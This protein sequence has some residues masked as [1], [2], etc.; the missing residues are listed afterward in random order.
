MKKIYFILIAIFITATIFAQAPEKMSYQAVIRDGGGNL[1]ANQG[2]GMQISILKSTASGTAVYVETHTPT[3]NINGLVTL[4]IGAGSNP[5]G[6]FADIDWS[7]D[8]YFIKTETDLTG[9]SGYTISGTSQLLSVPFALHAK[10]VAQPVYTVNT[11]YAELGG[12][13]IE[14]SDG[15]KHGIVVAMQNQGVSSWYASNDI[16]NNAANH[17][18]DGAKFKDWRLPTKRELSLIYTV[19][20]AITAPNGRYWSS[21]EGFYDSAWFHSFSN[22]TTSN[23][24]KNIPSNVRVVRVF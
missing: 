2:I 9:G 8:T 17:D 3:S 13:V 4:E 10:T 23:L 6:V 24:A 12:Y 20:A 18:V 21:T 16:C 11:F 1:V 5:S 14:V 15:G 7:N 19:K 22:D